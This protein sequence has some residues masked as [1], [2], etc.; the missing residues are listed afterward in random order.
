MTRCTP[1]NNQELRRK[2]RFCNYH[3][4]HV[5]NY[6]DI[7]LLANLFQPSPQQ[8]CMSIFKRKTRTSWKVDH[9]NVQPASFCC[10]AS[11]MHCEGTTKWSQM[12]SSFV[13]LQ[14]KFIKDDP[15]KSL[16]QVGNS[17]WQLPPSSIRSI[18]VWPRMVRWCVLERRWPRSMV[19]QRG[20]L[21]S[22]CCRP[23]TCKIHFILGYQKY[24]Y[25]YIYYR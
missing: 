18:R 4:Q 2:G 23:L 24:I 7:K 22:Y 3:G 17:L 11:C 5:D 1:D 20:S 12:M 25:M 15:C 19:P 16:L 10:L 21:E 8:R 9:C 14:C 13:L 6:Q